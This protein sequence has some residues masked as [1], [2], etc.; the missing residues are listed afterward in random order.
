MSTRSLTIFK[1]SGKEIAVMYK[2]YDGY[3]EGHGKDLAKFLTGMKIVNGISGKEP[4]KFA[5]GMGCLAAQVIAHFK[6]E[7]GDVAILPPGTRDCWEEYVYVISGETGDIEPTL[8]VEG[9]K[10]PVFEDKVSQ[11]PAF[12]EKLREE[13]DE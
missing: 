4:P 10:K 12:L 7:P 2:H 1:D 9:Y 5:N 11:F 8:T 3:P 13:E 6:T